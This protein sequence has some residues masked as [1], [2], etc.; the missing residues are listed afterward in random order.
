MDSNPNKY[1]FLVGIMLVGAAS[2]LVKNTP[3]CVPGVQY[4]P[5]F[6]TSAGYGPSSF[7]FN[8]FSMEYILLLLA[9]ISLIAFL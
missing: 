8:S 6:I 4:Y 1:K 2:N 7:A 9:I 5:W 3:A